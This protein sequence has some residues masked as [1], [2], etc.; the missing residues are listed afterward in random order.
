MSSA[1]D[2]SATFLMTNMIPQA[3]Q[4]NQQTW[5]NLEEYTRD[6]V[7][8]GNEVYVLMGSYGAG[9]TGSNG[10]KQ[11][12]DNGRVTVPAQIWKVLVVLPEGQ[13]DLSRINSSTRVIAV[14]TPNSQTVRSDWGAYRTSVDE[15]ERATGYDL[16]TALS[17]Q[18]QATLEAPVDKGPTQ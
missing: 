5:A 10:Q 7:A 12:I 3:P 9:G 17:N 16:L 1:A 11:T 4:H 6:L 8:A 13:D 18:V 14:N 2:N 15:I